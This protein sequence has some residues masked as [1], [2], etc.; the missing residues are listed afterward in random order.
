MAKSISIPI[1]GSAAPLRKAL[2]EAENGIGDFAK[3]AGGKF[4]DFGKAAAAGIAVGAGAVAA[5]A[6]KGIADFAGFQQ[7]MNEVFTLLPGASQETF[8]RL[9][10]QTKDFAKEFGVLPD[11]VIPALYQALSAGVPEGNVFDFLETAQKAAK[12]GVTDLETAVDG[13][14]SVVN[15]YGSDVIDA[16]KAS[17]IMFTAV[18]LGKTNF[19]ELSGSLYN[20]APIAASLGVNFESVAAGMANLTAKG[21]PTSVAATQMK[22]ALSELGKEG[23]KSQKAFEELTGMGITEFLETEGGF[24]DIFRIMQQGADDANISLLDMFGSIE[25]GQAALTL[26]EDNGNALNATFSQMKNSAGATDEAF[27]TMNSGINASLD[28]IKASLSV[29]FIDVGEKL[30]PVVEKALDGVLKLWEKFSDI[31]DRDG[32]KGVFN[33]LGNQIKIYGPKVLTVLGEWARMAGNWLV[34]TGLPFIVDKL[35]ALGAALVDW[36]RPRIRPMLEQLGELIAAGAN[37][38]FNDGLP[39]LV[40]K[41]VQLGDALVAWI[42]PNIRPMLEKLGELLIAIGDW[43]LTTAVPSLIENGLKL[44]GA[45]IGWVAELAPDILKGLGQL[46]LDIGTWVITE[47]I[48]KLLSAGADLAGG[49]ISGLVD[50][51]GQLGSYAA[52]I[53]IDIANA[54]IGFVNR[55]IIRTINRAVEFSI[56]LGFT[57]IDINPPDIPNIPALA[58]GG[59]VNSPTLALIGEAGP[60]AVIPLNRAGAMGDTYVTVNM[61]A[62]SN[63]DDVVRALRTYSRR[64][65]GLPLPTL[66]GVRT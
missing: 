49:L 11:E 29:L 6:A 52:D 35:Q 39:M 8:D 14:T 44:A 12:G 21:T 15:A 55:N 41:L 32:F 16:S 5:F 61:P 2:Q 3:R 63:G 22:A 47:G 30:A 9:T 13:L 50:G 60:E 25:A 31:F 26:A 33:E 1:T 46:I 65:G 38:I 56:P 34:N 27:A 66:A 43:I 51:L 20:V 37:W 53:A 42:K 4:A 54:L 57:S 36:I 28:R 58:A 45:L 59:I 24:S 62:G 18:K 23:T 64:N 48:P 10:S 19:E 17:D 40:D 7:Q